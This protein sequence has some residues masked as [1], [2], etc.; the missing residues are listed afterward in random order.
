MYLIKVKGDF[1]AAHR[2]CGYQ[3]DCANLHGHNWKVQIS[4][5]AVELDDLG[6]ACDF[7]VAKNILREELARWDH[8]YLNDMEIFRDICPTS[9]R[10]AKAIFENISS[11]LPSKLVLAAV[12]VFESDTSSVEYT[13]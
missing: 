7:R 13:P 6:M 5:E 1:S 8:H 11:K 9:E 12:E 3:G 4:I 2:I 10:I